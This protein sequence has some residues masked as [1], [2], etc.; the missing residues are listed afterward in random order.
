MIKKSNIFMIVYV[1]FL[2]FSILSDGEY[3]SKIALGATLAGLFFAF[4]DSF[5]NS[6][7]YFAPRY[8][9]LKNSQSELRNEILIYYKLEKREELDA[10]L[11]E[12]DNNM[13]LINKRIREIKRKSIAGYILLG[14]G[15][16][17]FLS[18][19]TFYNTDSKIFEFLINNE[20]TIT[21]LAFAMVIFNYCM[22]DMIYTR[23]GEEV[24]TLNTK[25]EEESNGE[26]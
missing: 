1:V 22:Q 20:N 25:S 16:F 24:D 14:L 13:I 26:T 12:I 17:V 23:H 11:K 10:C 19:L 15:I 3:L 6:A 7:Q 4:S 8:N 9:A 21:I 18:I 5:L 2:L